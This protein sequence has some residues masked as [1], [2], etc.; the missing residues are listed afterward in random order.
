MLQNV[1]PFSEI[2]PILKRVF[3]ELEKNIRRNIAIPI[4]PTFASIPNNEPNKAPNINPINVQ[5]PSKA[6]PY[7]TML[8]NIAYKD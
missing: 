4:P 1:M 7:I 2:F 3:K 5:M 8:F 6:I